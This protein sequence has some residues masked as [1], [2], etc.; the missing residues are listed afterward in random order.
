M[1]PL[2][3][4]LGG[5]RGGT[6]TVSVTYRPALRVHGG[7]IAPARTPLNHL[8][9]VTLSFNSPETPRQYV[10]T[11]PAELFT[12][13]ANSGHP[14]HVA[15]LS[16]PW[17]PQNNVEFREMVETADGNEAARQAQWF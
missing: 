6:G 1:N 13:M 4:I 3:G 11:L 15:D 2:T 17:S 8:P 10:V 14:V 12:A 16:F 5:A 9:Q 7:D